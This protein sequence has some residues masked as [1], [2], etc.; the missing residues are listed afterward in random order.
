MFMKRYQHLRH[1]WKHITHFEQYAGHFE[2]LTRF[3]DQPLVQSLHHFREK[4]CGIVQVRIFTLLAL[5]KD[6]RDVPVSY[7]MPRTEL[8]F[9]I[10]EHRQPTSCPCT[11]IIV[12]RALAHGTTESS[13]TIQTKE[14]FLRF[15]FV[16]VSITKEYRQYFDGSESH[17]FSCEPLKHWFT[18]FYQTLIN[19]ALHYPR[20]WETQVLRLCDAVDPS[21]HRL[22]Q[23]LEVLQTDHFQNTMTLR[24][25]LSSLAQQIPDHVGIC[26]T[27]AERFRRAPARSIMRIYVTLETR[28]DA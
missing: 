27:S 18:A 17:L 5:C 20:T 12:A 28:Q 21:W 4:D 8:A 16:N 1:D 3:C 2:E 13:T 14:A 6:G 10:L 24:M 7:K 11:A 9:R 26:S 22:L 19:H 15:D 23:P 25:P